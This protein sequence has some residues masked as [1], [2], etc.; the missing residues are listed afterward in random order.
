[1]GHIE[2]TIHKHARWVHF[3]GTG[4]IRIAYLIERIKALQSH[5][6]FEFSFNSFIDFEDATVPFEETG[7]DDYKSFVEALQQAEI[8]RKWAI[9][10][11]DEMTFQSANM[12]H[13]FESGA[14]EVDVFQN[15]DAALAFLG[16]TEDDLSDS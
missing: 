11:K 9:Y 15:R 3:R 10:T 12:S 7:I 6:D 2:F 16:I 14:I 1:M 13:L 5:P 8:H 4:A